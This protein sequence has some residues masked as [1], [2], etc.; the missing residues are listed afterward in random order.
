[1]VVASCTYMRIIIVSY[2]ALARSLCC[3][4]T[5]RNTQLAADWFIRERHV[6]GI[7]GE[8]TFDRKLRTLPIESRVPIN[9]PR[10]L[11]SQLTLCGVDRVLKTKKACLDR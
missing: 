10:C 9:P 3:H 6:N 4:V 2:V 7:C 5:H 8:K 1:M 11:I